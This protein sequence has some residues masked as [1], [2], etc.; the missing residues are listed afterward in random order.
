MY[1]TVTN[2]K[3][4]EKFVARLQQISDDATALKFILENVSDLRA[5]S[6]ALMLEYAKQ[7]QQLAMKLVDVPAMMRAT[8]LSGIAFSCN[9]NSSRGLSFLMEAYSFYKDASSSDALCRVSLE[10]ALVYKGLGEIENAYQWLG[11]AL[12]VATTNKMSEAEAQILLEFAAIYEDAELNQDALMYCLRVLSIYERIGYE[13]G[14]FRAQLVAM[15][16][17][18]K[19]DHLA[20][21][22]EYLQ[23][24]TALAEKFDDAQARAEL[25]CITGM[26]Y[27]QLNKIEPAQSFFH[28]SYQLFEQ[29]SNKSGVFRSL[30]H[31]ARL[32]LTSPEHLSQAR[33]FAEMA[34]QVAIASRN[35]AFEARAC[36]TLAMVAQAEGDNIQAAEHENQYQELRTLFLS[37]FVHSR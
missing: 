32:Y 18:L 8:E 12:E 36:Q 23:R 15:R 1:L 37:V 22:Q 11:R 20:Q 27:Q 21:A 5:E 35:P 29:L 33:T 24:A 14:I 31:L 7:A 28:Q 16:L 34:W 6:P 25:L 26:I 17:E 4:S 2:E 19:L 30:T 10:I 9:G 13:Y 3:L